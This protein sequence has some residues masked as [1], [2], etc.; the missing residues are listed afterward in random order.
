MSAKTFA[1]QQGSLALLV[2]LTSAL[3]AQDRPAQ[4]A[5]WP[6]F[7]GTPARDGKGVGSAPLLEANWRRPTFEQQ[8]TRA[9][10][11]HALTFTQ[12]RNLPFLP[13]SFPITTTVTVGGKER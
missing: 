10:I 1:V 5:N 2:A 7:G 4:P 6:L 8:K 13:T 9:W 11:D 12:Q 3:P